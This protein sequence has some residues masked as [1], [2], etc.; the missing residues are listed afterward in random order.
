MA[1]IVQ[2]SDTHFS[3]VGRQKKAM[4]V[5]F[6]DPILIFFKMPPNMCQ[7]CAAFM[8]VFKQLSE[9]DRRVAYGVLDVSTYRNVVMMAR[10][11]TTPINNVPSLILY[12]N[13]K[14]HTRF[15][16]NKNVQHLS[17]FITKSLE[18]AM[19]AKQ[20]PVQSQSNNMYGGMSAPPPQ[21]NFGTPMQQQ[22]QQTKPWMPE[23]GSVPPSGIKGQGGRGAQQ[24]DLDDE[25]DRLLIPAN[26]VPYNTPWEG[27]YRTLNE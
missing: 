20:T 9:S 7:G 11:T 6:S 27:D 18:S 22:N 14:P 23:F 15:N 16:G 4:V 24:R 5:N 10:E 25:D 26:V 13:G 8:P 19:T 3:L 12:I 2:L 17:S 21:Q 1:Q